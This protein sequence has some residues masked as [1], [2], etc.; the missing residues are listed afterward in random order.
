MSLIF[1]K[2]SAKDDARSFAEFV[3]DNYDLDTTIFDSQIESDRADPFPYKL[4]PPIVHVPRLDD[5]DKEQSIID[6][7]EQFGGTWAGT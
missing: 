5:L 4:E 1:D 3:K 6:S 2:F 7:V